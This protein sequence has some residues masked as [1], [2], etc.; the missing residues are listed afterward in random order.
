MLDVDPH[1]NLIN[2]LEFWFEVLVE[3]FDEQ[4]TPFFLKFSS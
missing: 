2:L 1:I 3:L 4:K